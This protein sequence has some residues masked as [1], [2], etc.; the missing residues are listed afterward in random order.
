MS[1]GLSTDE[2]MNQLKTLENSINEAK[3][4]EAEISGRIA[5]TKETLKEKFGLSSLDK[6]KS[7]V[8]KMEKELEEEQKQLNA[9]FKKL[10]EDYDW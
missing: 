6:S 9:A 3:R 4:E 2:I 8:K 5:M 7:M 1:D 10:K